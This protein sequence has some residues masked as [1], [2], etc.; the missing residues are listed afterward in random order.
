LM[1]RG[2]WTIDHSQEG[3]REGENPGTRR[4]PWRDD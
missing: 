4:V 1:N 2:H 3:W